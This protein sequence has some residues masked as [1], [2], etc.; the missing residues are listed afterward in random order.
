MKKLRTFFSLLFLICFSF[1]YTDK[2]IS[3]I[4]KNDPLM[5]KIVDV[6][7]EYKILPVNA[8]LEDNTIIPGLIGKEIDI[9]RSYE[10]MKYGGVFRE[11]ALIYKTLYPI[12][13]LKD[14]IDKYII[15]G[16]NVEKKVAIIYIFNNNY[17]NEIKLV[18]NITLFINHKDLT[19]FNINYLNDKEIYTY[20]NNGLY[21]N[22]QLSSDNTLISRLSNNKSIYCLTK[23]KNDK[24]LEICRDNGM[25]TIIPNII[26]GYYN[27]KENISNGSII[28]LDNLND[29]DVLIKY[30]N[31]RGF[32]I[33]GLQ[34]LLDE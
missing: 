11:D 23:E 7:S 18:D 14:N 16:N 6:K 2:V 33:V 19:I 20:G 31:S 30:I 27:I 24:T 8:I 12:N 15:K 13:S 1:F 22:E 3:V 34:E 28:L 26:G 21:S 10:N 5:K 9:D 17:I 4:N 29:I 32:N 25:Y